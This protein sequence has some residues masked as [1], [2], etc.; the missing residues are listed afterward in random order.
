VLLGKQLL[1]KI[2]MEANQAKEKNIW[3]EAVF[4]VSFSDDQEEDYIS[5][6]SESEVRC[7]CFD[8]LC[9]N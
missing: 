9:T 4:L 7:M 1:E 3:Y 6:T 2:L 5:D 8:Q